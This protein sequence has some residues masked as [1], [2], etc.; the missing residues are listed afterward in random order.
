MAERWD[1][2]IRDESSEEPFVGDPRRVGRDE[3][4]SDARGDRAQR[5]REREAALLARDAALDLAETA[6]AT[7]STS[8][9]AHP[10]PPATQAAD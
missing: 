8:A 2:V 1:V 9:P 6:A 3:T 4:A 7:A 10:V 5:A